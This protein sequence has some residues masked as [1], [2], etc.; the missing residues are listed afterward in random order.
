LLQA[1]LV[2]AELRRPLA[3]RAAVGLLADECDPGVAEVVGDRLET[4]RR[5]VEVAAAKVARALRR[6]VR[7]IR[8]A[9]PVAERSVLLGRLEHAVGE[10][11]G[12]QEAPEVIARV[13]EMRGR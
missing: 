8:E 13:G 9:D 11:G 2:L 7:G 10:A 1:A 5:A 12:V 6:P 4:R 3:E